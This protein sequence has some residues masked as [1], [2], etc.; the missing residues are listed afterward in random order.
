MKYKRYKCQC[1]CTLA[2][3]VRSCEY[4]EKYKYCIWPTGEHVQ[5]EEQQNQKTLQYG[6]PLFI[7]QIFKE[8]L[9][10]DSSLSAKALLTKLTKS[11]KANQKM[12]EEEQIK[13][14][15]TKQLLP[16]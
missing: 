9:D 11:R 4:S 3:V 13:L 1:K 7:Q 12:K 15:F 16:K 5:S 10:S 14:N 2:F 8:Y 6:V